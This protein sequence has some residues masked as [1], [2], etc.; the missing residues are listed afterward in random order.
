MQPVLQVQAE[1]ITLHPPNLTRPPVLF[2]ICSVVIQR[3][4]QHLCNCLLGRWATDRRSTPGTPGNRSNP[5][6]VLSAA[7][8]VVDRAEF[9]LRKSSSH[10][11]KSGF[12]NFGP[13][14]DRFVCGRRQESSD[15]RSGG[16]YVAT[17][18]DDCGSNTSA[19]AIPFT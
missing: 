6:H 17:N 8:C 15:S 2:D 7:N 14:D 18:F 4:P 10:N 12:K 11:D 19:D 5:R 9:L 3:F 1:S 13:I 16:I